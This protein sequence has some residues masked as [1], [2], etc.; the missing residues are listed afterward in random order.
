MSRQP[1]RF[2]VGLIFMFVVFPLEAQNVLIKMGTLAPEGTAWHDI[3]LQMRE[4]LEQDFSRQGNPQDLSQ[5]GVGRRAN[6]DP[7][8]AHQA[9]GR[10][11]HHR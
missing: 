1:L 2:T 11:R 7:K 3:L 8:D 6:H 10:S 4:D 5:W 9:V